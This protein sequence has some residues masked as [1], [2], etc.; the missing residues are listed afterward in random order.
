VAVFLGWLIAGEPLTLRT[1]LA[2][3]IIVAGV[4]VITTYREK[5]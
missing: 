3:G 2:A 1:I 4:G 5:V